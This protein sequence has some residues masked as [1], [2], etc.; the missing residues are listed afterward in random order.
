MFLCH[1]NRTQFTCFLLPYTAFV[2]M[3]KF[4]FSS[5]SHATHRFSHAHLISLAPVHINAVGFMQ[6]HFKDL[7][8]NKKYVDVTFVVEGQPVPAHR[9][10]LASQSN[11]FDRLFYGKMREANSSDEIPLPNAPLEAHS[12]CCWNSCTA[13]ALTTITSLCRLAY[14]AMWT[15]RVGRVRRRNWN[16]SGSLSV[17]RWMAFAQGGCGLLYGLTHLCCTSYTCIPV[18][19][20]RLIVFFIAKGNTSCF[21]VY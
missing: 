2:H 13:V 17:R 8:D 10:I 9:L 6:Q 21:D 15:G 5:P 3:F 16:M 18:H 11:Y 12:D 20:K 19:G 1:C 14:C 4:T 7:L